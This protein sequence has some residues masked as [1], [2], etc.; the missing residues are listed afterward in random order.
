MREFFKAELLTLHLKTGLQQYYKLSDA[1]NS[2]GLPDGER[3]IRI[4]ID[5]MVLVC[6]EFPM[7]PDE[8]KQ[9]IIQAAIVRD[10]EFTGLHSRVV[11][12]WLNAQKDRF[13]KQPESGEVTK[14]ERSPE[15]IARIQAIASEY[16]KTLTDFKPTYPHLEQDMKAIQR[17]DQ[18]RQEGKKAVVHKTPTAE[19]VRRRLLHNQWIR[20][21]HDVLTGAKLPCWTP[22]S[23]WLELIDSEATGD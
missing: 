2:E 21:N 10:Q 4:L 5:S 12:R 14:D 18:E 6:Q 15:E 3:Q 23:E 22:E 19:E 1:V 13:I 16:L 8:V 17:E 9:K 11:W 7:I 20:E